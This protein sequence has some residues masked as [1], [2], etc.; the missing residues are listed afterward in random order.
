MF[1]CSPRWIAG[2]VGAWVLA[3]M[4]P[5]MPGRAADDIPPAAAPPAAAADDATRTGSLVERIEA[6]RA[7]SQA[8]LTTARGNRAEMQAAFK[9]RR[10]ELAA[11]AAE[12]EAGDPGKLSIA[13]RL[14][15]ANLYSRDLQRPDDAVR[16]AQAVIATEPANAEAWTILIGAQA[17][18]PNTLDAAEDSLKK[19]AEQLSPDKLAALHGILANWQLRSGQPR[20]AADHY[21]AT[22]D[23]GRWGLLG[24]GG[25]PTAYFRRV[26]QTVGAYNRA[27]AVDAA[28]ARV[29][30]ELAVVASDEARN[31]GIDVPPAIAELTAQKIRLLLRVGQ[32][33]AA[34]TLLA[35]ALQNARTA[36]DA[37]PEDAS[38]V[39]A[40]LPLAQLDWEQSSA[41]AP[42][43]PTPT[44]EPATTETTA[45][46]LELLG[47]VLKNDKIDAKVRRSCA[48][49]AL[50]AGFQLLSDDRL[51]DAD[52]IAKLLGESLASHAPEPAPVAGAVRVPIDPFQNQVRSFLKRLAGE[53]ARMALVGQPAFPLETNAWVN[54]DPLTDEDLK[55]KVVLLDF[56]AV[57]C[58]PCIA[59][60]PHLRDWHE[61]YADRGLVIIGLTKYYNYGWDAA[62]NRG[63]KT[64]GL[65]PEDEQAA[66]VKFAEHHQ[67]KH[68][69]AYMPEG[70]TLSERYGVSGIPQ[71]VLIDREGKVRMIRV[72]SG[73]ANA[74]DLET[75]IEEL[76]AAPAEGA[77]T[78]GAPAAAA[79]A[80]ETPASP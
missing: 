43:E 29:D 62:A 19:A 17:G 12:A 55:G 59:C 74:H 72:G 38:R 60:F 46:Y 35:E 77:P 3:W 40:L 44:T 37:A 52:A 50:A 30:R 51:A 34:R 64:E 56:W 22:L 78:G 5:P 61:K 7:R 23:L 27:K 28:L 14:I 66:L 16:H 57:W 25:E 80:T 75:L 42:G 10:E 69:L 32:T 8:S 6:I 79:P 2:F 33:D 68:R 63:T 53:Q 41:D 21:A 48:Q 45:L 1:R 31:A 18:N 71:M 15:L 9:Q 73:E 76:L 26:E 47:K 11:L 36:Y 4:T 39:Q 54:G 49:S 58:G 65:T 70:A 13:D 67:L 20:V 24:A